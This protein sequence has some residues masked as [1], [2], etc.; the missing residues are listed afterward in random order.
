[1]RT[2]ADIE[3]G[4]ATVE[5]LG[6]SLMLF[7]PI[8]YLILTLAQ[9]QAATY[10]AES[11]ARETVRTYSRASS[12]SQ[13]LNRAQRSTV[14]IFGDHGLAISPQEALKVHCQLSPC[15][16]PG[17]GIHAEVQHRVDLPLLPEVFKGSPLTS[18][19]VTGRAFATIDRFKDRP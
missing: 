10:A 6:V 17:G 8:L 12:D 1:M 4:G 11:A 3:S 9:V 7:I 5:F 18:I 15:T 2:N 13:A 19:N 14:I 16:T